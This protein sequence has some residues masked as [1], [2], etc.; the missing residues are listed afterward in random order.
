MTWVYETMYLGSEGNR[1]LHSGCV[2][3]VPVIPP[4]GYP[5]KLVFVL[6]PPKAETHDVPRLLGKVV[7]Q[8]VQ[9]TLKLNSLVGGCAQQIGRGVDYGY[10]G[11]RHKL[12]S[13]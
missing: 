12:P 5:A 11:Y 1:V 9:Q 10:P 3:G 2:I 8:R 13:L 6:N 4:K 7:L